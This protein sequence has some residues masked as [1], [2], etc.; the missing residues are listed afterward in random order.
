[1]Y[2][3]LSA[4]KSLLAIK[5]L[6]PFIQWSL[7]KNSKQQYTGFVRKLVSQSVLLLMSFYHRPVPK[8]AD[9]AI[10]SAP[11][12]EYWRQELHGQIDLNFTLDCLR[13]WYVVKCVSPIHQWLYDATVLSKEQIYTMQLQ[14]HYFKHKAA[15]PMYSPLVSRV[16]YLIFATSDGMK[17]Q[18]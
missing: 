9:S 7:R 16:T 4:V 15:V 13:K 11:R 2:V 10:R 12:S 5:V 17:L 8:C 3:N 1:M 6:L 14:G 18:I